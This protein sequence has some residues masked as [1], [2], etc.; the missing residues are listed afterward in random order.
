MLT[1]VTGFVASEIPPGEALNW[2]KGVLIYH[3]IAGIPQ[4]TNKT[5]Q[6]SIFYWY[7][8]RYNVSDVHALCLQ[9]TEALQNTQTAARFS[10]I[11]QK[12][13]FLVFRS[14]CKLSMKPLADGP[15]DP[16]WDISNPFTFFYS[17]VV[18]HWANSLQWN[19][20]GNKCSLCWNPGMII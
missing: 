9:E 19:L 18:H 20:Q 4:T 13:A 14:L 15:P 2:C 7:K 5:Q 1:S 6:A 17:T 12:D 3:F 10:H 11:L 16:K 8:N